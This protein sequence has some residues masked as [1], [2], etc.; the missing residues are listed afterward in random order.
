MRDATDPALEGVLGPACPGPAEWA[1]RQSYFCPVSPVAPAEA[2]A[3]VAACP[4]A[5]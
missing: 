3:G 5:G 4:Q 1:V 2:G